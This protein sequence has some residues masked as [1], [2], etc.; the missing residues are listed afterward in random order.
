MRRLR[1]KTTTQLKP[2]RGGSPDPPR[3]RRGYGLG[4]G[5]CAAGPETRRAK[6]RCSIK[7]QRFASVALI[8]AAGL[9]AVTFASAVFAWA[10]R[11]HQ[12]I[13]EEAVARLPEP[14]R[15]LLAD[16]AAME[17]LKKAAIAPDER[18]NRLEK[19]AA[20]APPDRRE[21]ILKEA[22]EEKRRHYLDIDAITPEPPPFARF[23]RDR[24]AAEKEF[25]AKPFEEHGTVPWAA[26]DALDSLVAALKNGRADEIFP[27][28]GDL[29]HY[30]ADLHMPLHV[31]KNFNGRLT[32]NDGIHK[33]AE[34]G[35]VVRNEPFYAAEVRRGRTEVAYIENARDAFF[36]WI[37][38]ANARAAPILEADTAAR[39]AAPYN[40]GDKARA[41]EIEQE[42]EDPANEKPKPYYA[43]LKKE[44]ESR[45]SPEAV[46]MR[47]AAAHL[48]QLYYTAWVRAGKPAAL[49]AAP[50]AAE[51]RGPSLYMLLVPSAILFA[52]LLWPRRRPSPRP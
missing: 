44:L 38:Q 25:G 48:A 43:A 24:K 39:K 42:T 11:T 52:I 7:R 14:L 50:V 22:A 3:E 12:L 40:P 46:A 10:D 36:E 23:P 32:G 1:I 41:K 17:R 19:A 2:S 29:A 47:D 49:S 16:P 21:A 13:V 33:A 51:S 31:S 28:A 5:V 9:L 20:A 18:R 15:G 26:E 4:N 45:G 35:L 37:V 34:I 30:A 27:A 8:L 6:L